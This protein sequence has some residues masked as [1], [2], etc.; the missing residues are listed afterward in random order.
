MMGALYKGVI[1]IPKTEEILAQLVE[2]C[3]VRSEVEPVEPVTMGGLAGELMYPPI[4]LINALELGKASGVLEHDYKTDKLRVVGELA[5]THMGEEVER[6]KSA[7]VD[8][9]SRENAREQDLS[10]GLI[11]QWCSG[12]RP[13]AAELALRQLTD[14][15]TLVTYQFADPKDEASVYDFYTGKENEGKQWG[16]KQFKEVSSEKDS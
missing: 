1:M 6:L 12:V 14:S 8:A 3:R 4:F 7:I 10:L 5:T 15:G 11:Q 16:K 9:V 2:L 13:S